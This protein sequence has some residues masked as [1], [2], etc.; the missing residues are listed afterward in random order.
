M[1][2]LAYRRGIGQ[3][4]CS[5]CG[6]KTG[7]CRPAATLAAVYRG[8]VSA[9][10]ATS[11]QMSVTTRFSK[12]VAWLAIGNWTEQGI[13]F[14]V[15][16]LLARLLGAESF[17]LLAMA[18]VFVV[19]SEFLVRESISEFLIAEPNPTAQDYNA[20]FWILLALACVLASAIALAA[21]RI[22]AFY[23]E[24]DVASLIHVLMMTVP[25]IAATAVPVAIL[26]R[27]LRF[28]ELAIRA[29]AGVVVGGI[30][31]VGMAL[32][33]YGVWSLAGQRV[34]TVAT[35]VALAW[36]AV[37]WRPGFDT[38][39]GHLARAAR[40]GG[41][42]L[43]LRA[44]ELAATQVPSLVIGASLGAA[45][46]GLY[47]VAWRVVELA[48]FLIVTPLRVASQPTF[49][50]IARDGGRAG[51]LLVRIS[52]VT[53]VVAFPVFAGL[54]VVAQPF[55][56]VVFGAKWDAAA[57]V[58]SVLAMVGAFFCID[59]VQQSFCLA[60]GRPGRIT[61][62]SWLT[63]ALG[64]GLAVLAMPWGLIGV[65]GAVVAG[66][67]LPWPLR[68]ATTAQLAGLGRV[69]LVRPYLRPALVTV[70]MAV[71]VWA[72]VHVTGQAHPAATL[73]VGIVTGVMVQG[74]LGLLFLRDTILT[75]K[76]L[77]KR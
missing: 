46:L 45:P 5:T 28:R 65:A 20:V 2:T 3:P 8:T 22:A 48:S 52:Q 49:A 17:G 44:A 36:F 34:A 10:K 53:G 39:R 21:G 35:N 6:A 27:G 54:A 31:G 26:R 47:S 71:A 56:H 12:G 69:D 55:L 74:G 1:W 59:K 67:L 33:G 51:D 9:G 18:S 43:G 7:N 72:A 29:V 24:P 11:G 32:T 15:F 77:M 75:L 14:L 62:L 41:Q 73:A 25:L 13:N 57:P 63:V 19:L 66:Y 68:I 42:V 70:V 37:G 50:A 60:A 16:V 61:V 4:E 58:L 40:F 30:V 76:S 64:T 23:G 38:T